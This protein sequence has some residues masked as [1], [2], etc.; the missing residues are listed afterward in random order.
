LS[1]AA[2][3]FVVDDDD[4]LRE[5]LVLMLESRGFQVQAF[6]SGQAFLQG[7]TADAAGCLVLDMRMPE[8]SGLE[9]QELLLR[10]GYQLPILFLSAFADIPST[11][12]AIKGGAVDFLE[13]PVD[14]EQLVARIRQG[15]AEDRQRRR[16]HRA[17][18]QV[19]SRYEQLTPRQRDVMELA[20][21]GLSN[22]EIA[23]ALG[24][25]S[26]TV[27]NHRAL[28]MERMEADNLAVLCQM[29][30]LCRGEGDRA[31]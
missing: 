29:A 9:L 26:R 5:A 6:A 16:Q 15:L 22:K 18:Q 10:H 24:I 11:V 8:M 31:T 21:K 25:S 1:R 7:T 27:E 3:V 20:T 30:A 23:E 13:K 4:A 12:H 17:E 19:R 2:T 28:L 14:I